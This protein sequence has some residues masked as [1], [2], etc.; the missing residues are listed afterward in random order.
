MTLLLCSSVRRGQA[1]RLCPEFCPVSIWCVLLCVWTCSEIHGKNENVKLFPFTMSISRLFCKKHTSPCYLTSKFLTSVKAN[2]TLLSQSV[3]LLSRVRLFATP[4]IAARQASITN[5][6][7][8]LRLMSI[9]SV[10]PSSHLILYR[11]LLL[12]PPIPPS[13]K[14]FSNESPLRMRWPKYWSFSFSII[15]SKEIPGLI[16]FRMDWLDLLAVQGTLKESSPTPQFK[17]INSSVLSFL[18]SPTLTSIHDHWKNHN[19]D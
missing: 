19:L 14:V 12:L 1:A 6:Q 13:I 3:Q 16:S 7:S 8:S 15:P 9:E 5:S 4:W 17:S 18:H 2:F 11:P 10:M